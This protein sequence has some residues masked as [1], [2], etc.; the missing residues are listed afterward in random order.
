MCQRYAGRAITGQI[1]TTS[2]EA[3]SAEAHLPTVATCATQLSTIAMEKYLLMPETNQRRQI[4]TAEI[5]Q[6]TKKTSMRKKASEVRISIFW[7]TQPERTPGILPPWPQTV[8]H[9]SEVDCVKSGEAE[10]NFFDIAETHQGL[11]LRRPNHLHGWL[12]DER[13]S[14]RRRR[15]LGHCWPPE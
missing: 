14:N 11:E 12:S 7:S 6:L 4:A 2:V 9:V 10:K 8:N 15:H 1:K 13:Y 3:I 5:R